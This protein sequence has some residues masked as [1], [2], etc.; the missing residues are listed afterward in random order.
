MLD[1]LVLYAINELRKSNKNIGTNVKVNLLLPY[2]QLSTV[3]IL[4]SKVSGTYN[5][6]GEEITVL[7]DRVITEG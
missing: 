6:N 4:K 3:P 7:A 2:S 1:I 5:L